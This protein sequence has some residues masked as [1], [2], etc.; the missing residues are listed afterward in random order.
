MSKSSCW[1][2]SGRFEPLQIT[3]DAELR[4]AIQGVDALGRFDNRDLIPTLKSNCKAERNW[5]FEYT[6]I[7][8]DLLGTAG[9]LNGQVCTATAGERLEDSSVAG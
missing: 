5:S 4:E 2:H 6:R 9:H 8:P 7:R 3:S 1:N